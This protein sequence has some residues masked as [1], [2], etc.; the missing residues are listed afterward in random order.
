MEKIENFAKNIEA[1]NEIHEIVQKI[2]DETKKA[3]RKL[4]NL[5]NLIKEKC[6]HGE[7][8]EKMMS[9]KIKLMSQ[10]VEQQQK[11]CNEQLQKL[12]TITDC[13]DSSVIE[14]RD[15]PSSTTIYGDN[16]S[17]IKEYMTMQ[18]KMHRITSDIRQRKF[19]F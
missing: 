13:I 1:C 15:L 11:E 19:Y 3:Q 10:K 17:T 8:L 2:Q 14:L 6:E 12:K 4:G 7:F 18:S 9:Q 16:P 5:K